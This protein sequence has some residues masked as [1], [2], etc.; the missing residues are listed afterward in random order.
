MLAPLCLG[1][2]QCFCFQPTRDGF[3]YASCLRPHQLTCNKAFSYFR[4]QYHSNRHHL[5]LITGIRGS[6]KPQIHPP[7]PTFCLWA[8]TQL[9][10]EASPSEVRGA[11]RGKGELTERLWI[12]VASLLQ[13]KGC[14]LPQFHPKYRP[15]PRKHC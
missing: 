15:Q 12:S 9:T 11:W 3:V 13:Q 7:T 8:Q 6:H 10:A 14:K 4:N 5:A 2:L 1:L